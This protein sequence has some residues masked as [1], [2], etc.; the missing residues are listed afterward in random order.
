LTLNVE[1][2]SAELERLYD[3]HEL[4]ELAGSVLGP[5]GTA[6]GNIG[7]KASL[8]R[9][10]AE[11]CVERD[12]VEALLDAMQTSRRDEAKALRRSDGAPAAVCE[13]EVAAE[14]YKL[15]D[16]IGVG[17]SAVVVRAYHEV[18]VMRL[19]LVTGVPRKDTARYLVAMVR[20]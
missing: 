6:L 5:D 19:R 12:A 15:A 13:A 8:A 16:S 17:P 2:L 10:L 18:D 3:L 11:R 9:T 20:A 4:G 1:T 7:A 14:G